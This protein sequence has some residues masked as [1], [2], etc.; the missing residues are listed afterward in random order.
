[1]WGG[2]VP[3]GLRVDAPVENI[4]LIPTV[5]ELTGL[6]APP[7]LHGRSLLPLFDG[8]A[9]TPEGYANLDRI[10]AAAAERCGESLAI[11]VVVFGAERPAALSWESVLHDVSGTL[12]H[13]YGAGAECLYV[14][15]PDGHVGFRAQPAAQGPLL[16]H[17]DRIFAPV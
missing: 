16:E 17:L 8:A 13:E 14:I 3:S 15:R 9:P 4:D 7:G 1:M 2:G 12:A 6:E 11:H 10:A 5:L